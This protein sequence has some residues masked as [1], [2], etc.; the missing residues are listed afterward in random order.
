MA[1]CFLNAANRDGFY[2]SSPIVV[3]RNVLHDFLSLISLFSIRRLESMFLKTSFS[4]MLKNRNQFAP[5]D[6]AKLIEL[7]GGAEKFVARLDFMFEEVTLT[8]HFLIAFLNGWVP[9]LG[10]L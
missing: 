3:C 8:T 2:E 4:T 10:L 1:T 9:I 5:H 7:Q 6:T